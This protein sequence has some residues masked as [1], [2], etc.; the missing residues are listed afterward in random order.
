MPSAVIVL[1]LK[2]VPESKLT[3]DNLREMDDSKRIYR[4]G[5]NNPK[6]YRKALKSLRLQLLCL[7]DEHLVAVGTPYRRDPQHITMAALTR[8]CKDLIFSKG[9][10]RDMRRTVTCRVS[11]P[12]KDKIN[13]QLFRHSQSS[14][15]SPRRPKMSKKISKRW[16]IKKRFFD[17]PYN[18]KYNNNT[19]LLSKNHLVKTLRGLPIDRKF[20][21]FILS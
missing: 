16:T 1:C 3:I 15:T 13:I 20:L 9:S 5:R 17:W 19:N 21:S 10:H 4:A 7:F 6:R 8:A 2:D 18:N 14:R 12:Q 11:Q